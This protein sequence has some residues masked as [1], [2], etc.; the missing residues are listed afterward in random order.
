MGCAQSKKVDPQAAQKASSKAAPPDYSPLIKKGLV[1]PDE[2]KGPYDLSS[3][4]KNVQGAGRGF[5]EDFAG[6]EKW[7]NSNVEKLKE[8]DRL[9]AVDWDHPNAPDPDFALVF[10]N[11]AG[12]EFDMAKM[13]P[14]I[15]DAQKEMVDVY[16]AALESAMAKPGAAA[17]FEKIKQ[18]EERRKKEHQPGGKELDI[19]GLFKGA[20]GA[21][22][23]LWAYGLE[24]REASGERDAGL[25]WGIK[26]ALR[27]WYKL[28]HR[29]KG[30]VS[31]VTDCARISLEFKTAE[32]LLA[33]AKK[34]LERAS[35]FKNRV[36]NPTDEGYCDLMFTL[37]MSNGH[38]CEARAPPPRSAWRPTRH[39][40][41]RARVL[42]PA[43]LPPLLPHTL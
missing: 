27:I 12:L 35:T 3:Y 41:A 32:G 8:Y 23:E 43:R 16:R 17:A 10:C 34:L 14:K 42:A 19:V 37:P 9:E 22:G 2:T 33:A 13:R 21:I 4:H 31:C 7:M 24:V 11:L 29:Y 20:L 39:S 36:A 28:V 38:I 5:C 18:L 15:V 1:V 30:D 6:F 26:K 40:L 25:S